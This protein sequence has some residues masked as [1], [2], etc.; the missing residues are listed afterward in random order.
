MPSGS[1]NTGLK[2]PNT[3]GSNRLWH[4]R[5]RIGNFRFSGLAAPTTLR[6]W[7]H[8]MNHRRM[9]ATKPNIHT[10]NRT[11]TTQFVE[12]DAARIGIDTRDAPD[13]PNGCPIASTRIEERESGASQ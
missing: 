5:T 12:D 6:S 1:N 13:P 11:A 2:M 8:W 3:P 10:E 4:S 9:L 7:S